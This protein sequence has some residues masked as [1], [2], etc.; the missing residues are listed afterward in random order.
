MEKFKCKICNKKHPIYYWLDAG[1]P[2]V[3]VM[4]KSEKE[5]RV[6]MHNNI[7]IVDREVVYIKG[8]IYIEVKELENAWLFW[9]VW[10]KISNK[11]YRET[12]SAFQAGKLDAKFYGVLDTQIDYYGNTQNL[13]AELELG[14][15]VKDTII[16]INDLGHDLGQDQQNGVSIERLCDLMN[17]IHHS[18]V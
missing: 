1:D 17:G 18:S 7:Y 8:S 13:A 11:N 15:E 5:E 2:N 16:R 10:M 4:S 3:V 14:S 12:I 9:K 6:A